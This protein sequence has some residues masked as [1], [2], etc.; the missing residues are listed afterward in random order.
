MINFLRRKP[1]DSARTAQLAAD[2]AEAN[3]RATRALVETERANADLAAVRERAETMARERE[4]KAA[5]RLGP[6]EA[7]AERIAAARAEDERARTLAARAANDAA[8]AE[9]SRTA[10]ERR[11]IAFR[12]L[13]RR[14]LVA[15]AFVG[16][17]LVAFGGQAASY[18]EGAKWWLIAAIAVALVVEAIGL[19]LGWLAHEAKLDDDPA[20]GLQAGAYGVALYVAMLNYWHWS[21]DWSPTPEAAL[22]AGCSAVAPWLLHA[23]TNKTYAAKRRAQGRPL[24]RAPHYTK[25]RWVLWFPQTFG[26]VRL[27]IRTGESDPNAA[28]I[29]Y[30]QHRAARAL[31]AEL[32]AA[33]PDKAALERSLEAARGDLAAVAEAYVSAIEANDAER[34]AR[35]ELERS[36]AAARK[37][38]EA[39]QRER[40]D[41][42]DDD[43]GGVHVLPEVPSAEEQDAMSKQELKEA[44]HRTI[45]AARLANIPITGKAIGEAY[46]RG[47]RWGQLRIAEV[48]PFVV[49]GTVDDAPEAGESG[50]GQRA[51]GE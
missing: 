9:Q 19:A 2:V 46:D 33:D 37:A 26:E 28:A 1:E 21:N 35:A 15:S 38:L 44:A 18:A 10:A 32:A 41:E 25:A 43:G 34:A 48:P 20:G 5:I 11:E 13:I 50:N 30:E 31:A 45:R 27:A 22:F 24:P 8:E 39:N 6:L 17:S 49:A 29:A 36:H 14:R 23:Y 40:E 51:E 16:V 12:A 42:S 4:L 7:E 3:Q 47:E